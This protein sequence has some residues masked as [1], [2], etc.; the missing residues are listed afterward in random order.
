MLRI[1]SPEKSDGFGR[2]RTRD[3]GYQSG[4]PRSRVSILDRSKMQ[5]SSRAVQTGCGVNPEPCFIG[6]GCLLN[7]TASEA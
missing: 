5:F 4:Q 7:V 3:L 1:F 2:E 6:T